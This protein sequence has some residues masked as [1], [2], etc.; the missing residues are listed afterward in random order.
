MAAAAARVRQAEAALG[1]NASALTP[2]IA[3]NANVASEKFSY[4][5]LTPAAIVPHG[6]NDTGRATLLWEGRRASDRDERFRLYRRR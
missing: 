2:Q 3:A 6:M 1:V 4:N 5:Y